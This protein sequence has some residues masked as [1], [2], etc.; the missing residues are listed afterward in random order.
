MSLRPCPLLAAALVAML[1]G[2]NA[3]AVL[4][5]RGA[6]L[7]YDSDLDITWLADF[8]YAQT[9]GFDADGRMTW[10]TAMSWA[11]NLEYSDPVRGT[12]W[13]DWRLPTALD[14]DGSGPCFGTSCPDSELGH[15]LF[16]E[17]VAPNS[18]GP[19]TNF[20][21]GSY[22]SSTRRAPLPGVAWLFNFTAD[23][24]GKQDFTGPLE[25]LLVAFAVAVRDGDVAAEV[26]A[27]VDCSGAGSACATASCDPNG[28][29]G[30][31]DVLT[32]LAAGTE[33][34]AALG[35][36][37]LPELCDGSSG[38]CPEDAANST[39]ECRPAA[40]VCDLAEFCSDASDDCP[41]DD[42]AP[43]TTSCRAAQ[44]VCDAEEFC[45]G[46]GSC[47][48]DG[49]APTT[50]SCRAAQGACDAEEFCDGAG[51]CPP[52]GFEPSTTSCDDGIACTEGDH[53]DGS[54]ACS[55]GTANDG[56]CSDAFFCNGSEI[57]DPLLGCQAGTPP[58]ADDGILCTNEIC[59]EDLDTVVS[60]PE[61]ASCDDQD[62]CTA[63]A[64]DAVTGCTHSPVPSCAPTDVP[65]ASAAG[66][67]LLGAL[68]LL[69]A[70]RLLGLE[71]RIDSGR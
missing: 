68:L 29:P 5:D 15:L 57:C 26:C 10:H 60:I 24:L 11:A 67:V 54:G 38:V 71:R 45:D 28:A 12:T 30:N 46:A 21:N 33:C 14:P 70:A 9:S 42:F 2:T 58:L 27:G 52:D 41:P 8:K 55:P 56:L 6:G 18:P 3:S 35:V 40:G 19:F 37:D 4:T 48:P 39:S 17:G 62:P 69:V 25:D 32:P 7:I 43:I 53:C 63:D 20:A 44:G 36:C 1:V 61:D 66:R 50:T 65:A 22:W 34:R 47:P 64:C 31:C 23:G 49:F 13:T 16:V 59:D 51:S